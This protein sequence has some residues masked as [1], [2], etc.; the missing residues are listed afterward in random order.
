[1]EEALKRKQ[2]LE[3]ALREQERQAEEHRLNEERER[4]QKEEAAR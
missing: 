3:E 1:M 4:L 2:Q